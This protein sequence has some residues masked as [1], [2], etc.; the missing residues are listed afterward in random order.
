[1]SKTDQEDDGFQQIEF[2]FTHKTIREHFMGFFKLYLNQIPKLFTI[3][4]TGWA[5]SEILL[6]GK[7]SLLQGLLYPLLF[8]SI[9]VTL[10]DNYKKYKIDVPDCLINQSAKIKKIFTTQKIAWQYHLTYEFISES[11]HINELALDRIKNG[12]EYIIPKTIIEVDYIEY[13]KL[14]SISLSKLAHAIKTSCLEI[15]KSSLNKVKDGKDEDI[16]ILVNSL[17]SLNQLYEQVVLFEKDIYGIVPPTRF[18]YVHQYLYDW[19]ETLRSVMKQFLNYIDF[20]AKIT[21]KKK[22]KEM[23]SQ[24]HKISIV[25]N[26]PE[27][28]EKFNAAIENIEI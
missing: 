4:L 25:F 28:L 26:T 18:E 15:L 20:L 19:T 9:W 21:T 23:G 3:L 12:S 14:K 16:Y 22:I 8:I 27:N 13:V 17:E 5:A 11:I 10:F 7:D 6:N 1:M 24:I 2:H